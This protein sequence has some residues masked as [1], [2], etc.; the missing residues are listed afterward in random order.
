MKRQSHVLAVDDAPFD[1]FRDREALAVGVVTAGPGLVE[2]VLTTRLPV[3]ARDVTSC[4]E[5]WI[6]ASRLAPALRAVLFEGIT[7]A[8]LGVIDLPRLSSG[9]G[10][11][12]IAVARKA[13]RPGR[14]E[15][16]LRRLGRTAG[17]EALAAAGPLHEHAGGCFQA[18]GI[19]PT[20]ARELL[21]RAAGRSRLPEGLRLA[22][23]IAG[24]MVLGQSQGR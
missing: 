22:H 23:L 16:T 21:A 3:D 24:G 18:A 1:R 20:A 19:A 9:L 10:L 5:R 7:I 11:P 4:L 2:A 8:G 13:P 14:L 17:L 6:R 15:A 12:V